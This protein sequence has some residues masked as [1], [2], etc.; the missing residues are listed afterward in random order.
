MDH[1][2]ARMRLEQVSVPLPAPL[3]E[4]VDQRAAQEERSRA[5]IIRR[6]VAQAWKQAR[7]GDRAA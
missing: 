6:L 2:E 3:I 7:D 4:F 5:A 1:V